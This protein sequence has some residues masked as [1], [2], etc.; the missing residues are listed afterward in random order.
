MRDRHIGPTHRLAAVVLALGVVLAACAGEPSA[1][2]G[3]P[4]AGPAGHASATQGAFQLTFELPRTT[5]RAGEAIEGLAA[6]AVVGGA[7]VPFGSSGN[8]PFTFNF[9]E[10]GGPRNVG[11][12]MTADCAPYRLEPGR[13]MTSAITKSGGWSGDDPNAPFYSA[14][15]AD[16]VIRLPAGD[17]TITAG[18]TL[19]E[20]EGCSG[21]GRAL[22]A[23][24]TVHVTP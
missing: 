8:G 17:W 20:G 12:L 18:A 3:S 11:G 19:V 14:F 21:A 22:A 23:P 5:Y 13:P 6:L 16:P 2:V 15:L 4:S 24:I 10:V 7:P 9:A 1:P